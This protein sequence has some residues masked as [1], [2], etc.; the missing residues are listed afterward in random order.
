MGSSSSSTPRFSASLTRVAARALRGVRRRHRHAGHALGA[1]GVDGD[2]GHQRRVDPA[3]EPDD[4]VLEAA[5]GHVVARAEDERRVDL[6]VGVEQ[7]GDRTA[8]GGRVRAALGRVGPEVGHHR[9]HLARRRPRTRVAQAGGAGGLDVDVAHQERLGELR[10]AGDH[11][12]VVVD[13]ERMAVEDELVLAADERAEGDRGEAVAGALGDH[14]LALAALAG[15]VGRGGD[16]E[17]QP[18]A[19]QRLVGHRRTGDPD[20]LADGEADLD[21]VDV[22]G[23]PAGA[24]LEVAQLVEDPV[25]GQVDLAVDGLQAAVGQHRGGVVGVVARARGS[26]RAPRCPVRRRRSARPPPAHRPG[27]AP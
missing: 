4:H 16:V 18:R 7:L 15:L 13:D 21:S 10:R 9:R 5:L 17:H 12:A 27:S 19:G 24:A 6:G 2:E 8:R 11:G 23:R 20:V 22:D 14:L 25:V 3:R 1:E 26:R